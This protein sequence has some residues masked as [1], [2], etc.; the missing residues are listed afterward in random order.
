MQVGTDFFTFGKFHEDAPIDETTV[1]GQQFLGFEPDF[2]VNWQVTSDV[3]LAVRYGIFFPNGSAFPIDDV[4]QF[5]FAGVTF[6]F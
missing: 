5:F 1:N 2:Y 3:T 6:A 4:R